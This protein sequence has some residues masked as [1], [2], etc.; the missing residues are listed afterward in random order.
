MTRLLHPL[1]FSLGLML[2]HPAWSQNPL[3]ASNAGNQGNPPQSQQH[4]DWLEVCV[5]QNG[6][7]RCQAQQTLQ[8]K[9][10]QGAMRMLQVTVSQDA[11]GNL[12]LQLITPL[13]V[14]V[15]S[16][17]L[18]KVDEGKEYQ[19]PFLTCLQDGCLGIH[20]LDAALLGAMKAGN[21]AKVAFRPFNQKK[22]LVINVSLKGFTAAIQKV[23]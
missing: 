18:L 16:G 21:T 15:A 20:K 13:G 10:Q 5:Q 1:L 23:E 19:I 11:Q 3:P 12:G 6:Q 17:L 7:T 9:T 22:P 4:G 2:V 8:R 14:N